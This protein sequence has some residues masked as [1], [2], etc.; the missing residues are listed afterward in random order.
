MSKQPEP[1]S[2]SHADFT[3][4]V[5][6]ET[7]LSQAELTRRA[8]AVPDSSDPLLEAAR[9]NN[10]RSPEV[11]AVPETL[12]SLREQYWSQLDMLNR[13][14]IL[15]ANSPDVEGIEGQPYPVPTIENIERSIAARAEVLERKFEAGFTKLLVVPFAMPLDRL[16]AAYGENLKQIHSQGKLLDV[17]GEPLELDTNEPVWTWDEMKGV[18]ADGRLVYR[19]QEFTESGH[20][21]ITKAELL[22][23]ERVTPGWQ[24]VLVED[25]GNLPKEGEGKIVGDRPQLITGRSPNDDLNE[26]RSNPIYESEYGMTPEMY[27]TM[28]MTKLYESMRVPDTGTGTNLTGAWL[29]GQRRVPYANWNRGVQ[30]TGLDAAVP[31]YAYGYWG[32]RSAVR[33][34]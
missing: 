15:E 31:D 8:D 29:P 25:L 9:R 4:A 18:D 32:V 1:E 23:A 11:L 3:A 24:V 17:M 10:Q 19:P 28:A 22:A 34:T 6:A 14:G 2:F 27:F 7:G 5:A 30:Q 33:V 16:T 12:Q 21:G 20:G 26:L 13:V